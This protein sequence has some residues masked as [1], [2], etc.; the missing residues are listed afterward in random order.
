MRV[1]AAPI[2]SRIKAWLITPSMLRS[3]HPRQTSVF[4][5]AGSVYL[6]RIPSPG[7]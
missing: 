7:E 1:T 5:R 3:A 6:R 4:D 2:L